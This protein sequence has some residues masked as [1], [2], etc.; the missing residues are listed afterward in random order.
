MNFLQAIELVHTQSKMSLKAD[1][2]K[3][4]LGYLWWIIEPLLYVIVFYL[5][6]EV[7]LQ[8]GRGEFLLFLICGKIPFLWFSKSITQASN[9]ITQNKGLIAQTVIPK[10][11]FPFISIQEVL[12]KQ[13]LVFAVM[14]LVTA[15]YGHSPEWS[16]L[17]LI[18]L[19]IV[20]Y[21]LIVACSLIGA[22]LVSLIPDF[23]KMI[24]MAM[25]FLMFASGIF[26]DINT[27]ANPELREYILLYNPL[28]FL[29]DAYR[30][31]LIN[32][33]MYELSHLSLLAFLLSIFVLFGHI[34]LQK[35]DSYIT[36]KVISS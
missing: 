11:I 35:F 1:A 10:T 2:S 23:R 15:F 5:V 27:I 32:Q 3:F 21:Q 12:Y 6:F 36:V 18:P 20:Q 28:A 31:V 30:Q 17:W 26:W 9:S 8:F 33:A 25:L 29:I 19:I 22:F 14:F 4:Y 16:W 24:A 34:L 13:W 7:V